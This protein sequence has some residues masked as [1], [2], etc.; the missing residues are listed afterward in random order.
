[1]KQKK[2]TQATLCLALSTSM[3]ASYAAPV[4]AQEPV[5][6]TAAEQTEEARA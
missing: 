3:I 1:M 2:L 6:V 5:S 4:L